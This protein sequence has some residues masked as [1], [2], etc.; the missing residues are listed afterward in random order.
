[1]NKNSEDKDAQGWEYRMSRK[2]TRHRQSERLFTDI[3][4]FRM[5]AEIGHGGTDPRG[6]QRLAN[7]KARPKLLSISEALKQRTK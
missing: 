6:D 2:R 7:G 3:D 1:V 5:E 4:C